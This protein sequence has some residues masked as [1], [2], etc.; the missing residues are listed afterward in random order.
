MSSDT[1]TTSATPSTWQIPFWFAVTGFCLGLLS[2][3]LAW[4]YTDDNGQ[5]T[6]WLGLNIP[7]KWALTLSLVAAFFVW[8][9][10]K[11]MAAPIYLA[12]LLAL[13]TYVGLNAQLEMTLDGT[14]FMEADNFMSIS[15]PLLLSA[16][17]FITLPFVQAWENTS[18]HWQYAT[19]FAYAWNN[20]HTL[21]LAAGFA[22]ISFITLLFGTMLLSQ[23]GLKGESF[24][25][26]EMLTSHVFMILLTAGSAAIG[27]IQQY[28]AVLLRLHTLAFA[29]Y[30]LLAYAAAIITLLFT[31]N[32]L[33]NVSVFLKE[34]DAALTLLVLVS[35]SILLLNTLVEYGSINLNSLAKAL[36]SAHIVTLP[37]L[38]C[39]AIYAIAQRVQHYGLSPARMTA[40]LAGMLLLVYSL[41]YLTQW[42]RYRNRWSEGLKPVNPPLALLAAILMLLLLTP[43]LSPQ[44]WSARQQLSR[45]QNGNVSAQQFDYYYLRHDFGKAGAEAIETLKTWKNHP[46]Y[47]SIMSQIQSIDFQAAPPL[48]PEASKRINIIPETKKVD[49][50]LFMKV[51]QQLPQPHSSLPSYCLEF[52]KSTNSECFLL[53]T[54]INADQKEEAVLVALDQFDVNNKTQ[55]TVDAILMK[56][57]TH[58]LPTHVKPLANATSRVERRDDYLTM[59]SQTIPMTAQAFAQVRQALLAG[60]L[61]IVMPELPDLNIAGQRLYEQ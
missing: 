54:D 35:A 40:L 5:Y 22:I 56:L 58:G 11:C 52:N 8:K 15:S 23:V 48:S 55:Y 3:N 31:I 26:T 44:N 4:L 61:T 12:I 38:T 32:L 41:V 42:I 18:P 19:L 53:F 46:Q 10:K 39:F 6:T 14:G 43:I 60:Q 1:N 9:A 16:I 7:I 21:L 27:I 50:A 29:L 59:E 49:L 57:D 24:N 45:L 36:F 20:T 47:A 2:E 37:L 13:A 51:L 34:S 17:V 33:P 30:R 25:L 28:N